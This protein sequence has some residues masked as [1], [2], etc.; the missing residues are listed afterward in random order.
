MQWMI[1]NS[2]RVFVKFSKW[3]TKISSS[4][5]VKTTIEILQGV[6]GVLKY[7]KLQKQNF[8]PLKKS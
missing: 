3:V 1:L 6:R 4:S 5:I 7:L 2:Q 8:G